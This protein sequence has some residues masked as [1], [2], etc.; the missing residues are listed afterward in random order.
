LRQRDRALVYCQRLAMQNKSSIK[1]NLSID[2]VI[3]GGGIAGVWLLRLLTQ[4]GY[5]TILLEQDSLGSGQT[6][7]SQGMIH[8]G[9]KYALSGLLSKESE[10]I[11]R[12]PERW[13]E[14][15]NSKSGDIDLRKVSLLS[16]DYYMFSDGQIG[17]L[18]SFFASK[19]LR[20]R[21]QKVDQKNKP[22]CFSGFD[23]LIYKL[24]DFVLDTESLLSE[25]TRGLEDRI[26]KLKCS[27]QNIKK[28][29]QGYEIMLSD[30]CIKSSVLINCAGNGSK[31]LLDELKI[32][33]FKTQNRPLKQII[34]DA[35]GQLDMF[36]HCI[37]NLSTNEPRMTIT[38]H[39]SASNKIWY[40]G[41]QLATNGADLTDEK[42]IENAKKELRQCMPWLTITDNAWRTFS[43]DRVEPLTQ[44]RLKPNEAFAKRSQNFLQC[45]PTKLTLT[46]DLGDKVLKILD[47]PGLHEKFVS[48]HTRAEIGS[49]PW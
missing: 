19:S 10:A 48:T 32:D 7:A 42:L 43:V 22:V 45:F 5:N 35:P 40:V 41:G 38:T 27:N 49:S 16:K 31:I 20:G 29:E 37:T 9:L 15:L 8:G 1:T 14:C 17:K 6:L 23:G 34:L 13:R 11:S 46:P 33:S 18:A 21:I 36:A 25:L 12:M 4:K 24:N 30:T 47:P 28:I 44:N 3:V 26:L 39:R 2:S